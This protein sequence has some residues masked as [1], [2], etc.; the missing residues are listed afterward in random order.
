[1]WE[2]FF[3][4]AAYLTFWIAPIALI[5]WALLFFAVCVGAHDEWQARNETRQ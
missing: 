3:G 4:G 1:M 5:I 2:L